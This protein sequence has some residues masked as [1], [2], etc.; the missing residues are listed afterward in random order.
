MQV[1][2]RAVV[3]TRYQGQIIIWD[4]ELAENLCIEPGQT[5]FYDQFVALCRAQNFL[6]QC[7][8]DDAK[9]AYRGR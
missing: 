9:K 7:E 6:S 2:D 5:L 3:I 1:N 8:R 4:A